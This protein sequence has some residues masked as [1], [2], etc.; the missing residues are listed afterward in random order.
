MELLEGG[1]T[2]EAYQEIQDLFIFSQIRSQGED[3]MSPRVCGDRMPLS[4]VPNFMRAIGFYPTEYEV[5]RRHWVVGF[6]LW[7]PRGWSRFCCSIWCVCVDVCC[8]T[9]GVP[10]YCQLQTLVD[11]VRFSDY[12][13]TGAEVDSVTLAEAVSLYV[14]HRPVLGIGKAAIQDA[15]TVIASRVLDGTLTDSKLAWRNVVAMLTDAGEVRVG[16]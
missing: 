12:T 2:G 9:F 3:T 16:G 10:M 15:L 6:L 8:V 4:E 14:N 11:E 5:R 1:A 7:L 13:I